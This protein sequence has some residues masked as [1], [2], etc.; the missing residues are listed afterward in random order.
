MSKYLAALCLFMFVAL[1][2]GVAFADNKGHLEGHKHGAEDGASV[3]M[4]ADVKKH[5]ACAH[6]GMDREKFSHSRML[7]TYADRASVGVCSIHCAAI[8]M[9]AGKGKPVKPLEVAD[10]DTKKLINA[11]KAFWVIGGDKKGVMTRTPKWAF[12]SK[13]AA[14]SFIKK[15]GGKLTTYREALAMA[16]KE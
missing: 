16:E 15:S 4:H 5:N 8:E 9:K 6:C 2:S 12:A 13:S 7:V 1:A 10:L 14:E 3:S 11:E